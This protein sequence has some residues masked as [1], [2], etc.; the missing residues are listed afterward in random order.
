MMAHEVC[1]WS[2][3]LPFTAAS[4]TLPGDGDCSTNSSDMFSLCTL[5]LSL[6]FFVICLLFVIIINFVCVCVFCVHYY[7]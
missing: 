4:L 6:S 7:T 1:F 5:S 3:S 2:S